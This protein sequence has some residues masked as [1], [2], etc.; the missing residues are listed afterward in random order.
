MRVCHY[1][2]C[3][4]I[5]PKTPTY[6]LDLANQTHGVST[7]GYLQPKDPTADAA[8]W[9]ETLS[10]M[11]PTASK[12]SLQ[13]VVDEASTLEEAGDFLC[14]SQE[15]EAVS[16]KGVSEESVETCHLALAE[17]VRANGKA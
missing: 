16:D 6:S 17:S 2:P 9:K 12:E 1:V 11:F 14:E 15:I 8:L 13:K 4:T 3:V 7:D 5:C 10:T